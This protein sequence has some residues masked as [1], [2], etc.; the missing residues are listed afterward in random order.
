M[1]DERRPQDIDNTWAE[2]DDSDQQMRAL[3]A[4]HVPQSPLPPGLVQGI[5]LAVLDEVKQTYRPTSVQRPS[6]AMGTLEQIRNWWRTL[7][8]GQ[9]L[10]MSGAVAAF[11]LLLL[12]GLTQ[13]TP[14][15]QSA[16]VKVSDGS[17]LVLRDESNSF[18]TFG[19]GD[20]LKV[21]EGDHLISIESSVSLA[22]FATQLAVLQPGAHLEIVALAEEFGNTQVEYRVHRGALRNTIDEALDANDRYIIHSPILT[23]SATGTDF[24]V[25]A[26]SLAQTRVAVFTG[27]VVVAMGDQIVEVTAGH[28]VDASAG[29]LLQVESSAREDN[30][31]NE[32]LIVTALGA[33]PLVVR[34]APAPDAAIIGAIAPGTALRVNQRDNSGDWLLVC[35]LAD[36]R[37]GWVT[38]TELV[39]DPAQP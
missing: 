7:S 9:S 14:Q 15:T 2:I 11:G 36:D 19:D 28:H 17:A 33:A 38:V 21:D 4:R 22:P 18:R 26:S 30:P 32:L 27:T 6:A 5:Q 23:V 34:D 12:M 3:F 31:S 16:V 24:S 25:E 1:G 39:A 10:V 8:P 13:L 37:T 20:L 35:C 29:A